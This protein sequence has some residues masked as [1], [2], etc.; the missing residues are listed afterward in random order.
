MRRS[1]SVVGVCVSLAAFAGCAGSST[2]SPA[3]PA[4][5]AAASG[6]AASV[7][8]QQISVDPTALFL[9]C[10][11]S[12]GTV[13]ASTNFA[14][15]IAAAVDANHCSVSPAQQDAV[16]TAGSGGAKRATFTV[17]A[18]AGHSCNVTLTDKKGNTVT[19]HVDVFFDGSCLL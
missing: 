8:G 3:A 7:S 2:G 19:V 4:A 13:T 15:V 1:I 18:T 14:G 12:T 11:P 10:P 5:L 17:T 16:V 6:S 9:G